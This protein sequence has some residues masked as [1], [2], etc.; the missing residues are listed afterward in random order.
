MNSA[1]RGR[2]TGTP[3]VL[4]VRHVL[5]MLGRR[6]AR[7]PFLGWI[8][9]LLAELT[10][11]KGWRL[12]GE[13]LAG[14]A[15]VCGIPIG[16]MTYQSSIIEQSRGEAERSYYQLLHDLDD[17]SLQVR[18]GAIQRIPDLMTQQVPVSEQTT[19]LSVI[20]YSFGGKRPTIAVYNHNLQRAMQLHLAHLTQNDKQWDIDEIREIIATLGTLGASGWYDAVLPTRSTA[21]V[22]S[23]AW[24]W[25]ARIRDEDVISPASLFENV[26]LDGIDLEQYDLTDADFRGAGLSHA[27]L[28][29]ARLSQSDFTG[30]QLSDA[31]LSQSDMGNSHFD[32]AILQ[33]V[34][35]TG[36]LLDSST[37]KFSQL[38]HGHLQNMQCQRCTFLRADLQFADIQQAAF[39]NASLQ[40]T[41]FDHAYASEINLSGADLSFA[42]LRGAYLRKA[43]LAE[44]SL[45]YADASGSNFDGANLSSARFS[46]CDLRRANLSNVIG[47]S[48]VADWLDANIARV[49]GLSASE[50]AM[51]LAKGAVEIEDDRNWRAY[52]EAGRPHQEWMTYTAKQRE[53]AKQ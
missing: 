2:L 44:A 30:A 43:N 15:V 26:K 31:D 18:L 10:S 8:H 21:K 36:A 17:Q 29:F 24:I 27:N 34:Y 45:N 23:L 41:V 1:Q 46:F 5:Q 25:R 9:D 22:D 39:Q 4:R 38:E 33:N 50:R 14:V 53:R 19:V 16:L 52:R 51:L 48:M 3:L 12:F 7:I 32:R 20:R 28:T 6:T 13:I 40:N 35:L 11:P 49:T 37:F 42:S 47:L